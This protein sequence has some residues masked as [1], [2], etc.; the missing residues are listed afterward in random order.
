MKAILEF[1]LPEEKQE[2][3]Y[4]VNATEAFGALS[5]IQQQLR[6][7]RKYDADPQEV[8]EAIENIVL[9]VNW[10]YEQ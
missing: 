7:I 8:L 2:H 3:N 5:D 10:K 1:N 6:R 9:E 4:A